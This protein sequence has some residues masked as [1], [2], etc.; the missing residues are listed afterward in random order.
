ME[1]TVRYGLDIIGDVHGNAALLIE[2]LTKLGYVLR[3]GAYVHPDGRMAAFT[4]DLVDGGQ[5]N[6]DVVDIVRAMVIA[7]SGLA[8]LGNHDFNIV[9]FNRRDP[10]RPAKF[11]RSHSERHIQQ[12]AQTQAEI[13][14][15]PE[16][17][18]RALAF[19]ASLP[20]WL[21]LPAVRLVHAHWDL[22]SM[23]ALAPHL[24]EANA[25][26]HE[27]FVEAAALSGSVGDARAL[28]LSG[29][30]A[31]CAPYLD[32]SGHHRTM[33]RVAWWLKGDD[34]DPRPLFFGHYAMPTPLSIHGNAVCVDAGVAKGG[35]IAAY[36]FDSRT[37]LSE[38]NF[39]YCGTAT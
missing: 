36:R 39:V 1:T 28:L 23:A 14:A 26:T 17:G 13:D 12:C 22:A 16:R 10:R 3:D 9:A 25:L 21:E 35:P 8:I 6:L 15:D 29:P 19:L 38:T 11:L 32:R 34:R 5:R 20:L 30:E 2:L 27:G 37:D 4:G 7:G 33:D 18:A 31:E 24:D